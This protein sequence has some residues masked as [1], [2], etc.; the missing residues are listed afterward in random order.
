MINCKS[1]D[2]SKPATN[3]VAKLQKRKQIVDESKC[4]NHVAGHCCRRGFTSKN[5]TLTT[6]RLEHHLNL[7]DTHSVTTSPSLA[8]TTT[9]TT[10]GQQSNSSPIVSPSMTY[11]SNVDWRFRQSL[12]LSSRDGDDD[13][14]DKCDADDKIH[15]FIDGLSVKAEV[16]ERLKQITPYNY[17]G[18]KLSGLK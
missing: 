10:T 8:A 5:C 16:K 4:R 7:R 14:D 13:N 9:T 6:N 18:L 15:K 2:H 3:A 17:V 11:H 1:I 12:S